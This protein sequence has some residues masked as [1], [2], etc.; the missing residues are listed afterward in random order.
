[1]SRL[2]PVSLLVVTVVIATGASVLI[3]R[4]D[5][6]PTCDASTSEPYLGRG[7]AGPCPAGWRL[8]SR[9]L[10]PTLTDPR[11]VFAIATFAM[12]AGG[13]LCAHVPANAIEDLPSDG[14]LLWVAERSAGDGSFQPRPARLPP[15]SHYRNAD[16][17]HDCV[18]SKRFTSWWFTFGEQGRRFHV[19]V[20]FGERA[21]EMTQREA[22]GIIKGL[23]VSAD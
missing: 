10:T 6:V 16:E 23:D 12:R 15:S 9:L 7:L 17:S 8:S 21:S 4:R 19:L 3:A 2:R 14:A 5:R 22:W 18:R 11:E 13:R 20:V 1:M